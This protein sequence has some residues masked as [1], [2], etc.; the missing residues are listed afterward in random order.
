[1]SPYVRITYARQY[2]A[3]SIPIPGK[4]YGYEE[5]EIGGLVPQACPDRDSTIGPAYYNVKHV[6]NKNSL[7][8]LVVIQSLN[9]ASHYCIPVTIGY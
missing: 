6:S 2:T 1:M 8:M 5:K 3:P 9:G 7:L 4:S